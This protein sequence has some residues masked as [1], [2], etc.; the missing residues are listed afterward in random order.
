MSSLIF[1]NWRRWLNEVSMDQ[2]LQVL[3]SKKTRKALEKYSDYSQPAK[4]FSV[5]LRGLLIDN[6]DVS[7]KDKALAIMWLASLAKRDRKVFELVLGPPEKVG[8]DVDA[9]LHYR[10]NNLLNVLERFFHYQRF[11][12]KKD[13]LRISSVDELG[14]IVTDAREEIEA[15]QNRQIYKDAAAGTEVLRDDARWYI[16]AIHNKGAACELGKG[17]KWCTAAPGLDYFHGYYQKDSPLFFFKDKSTGKRY[18]FSYSAEDFGTED[19]NQ[20]SIRLRLKLSD[21]LYA[22]GKA[23][24]YGDFVD[25]Y[26]NDVCMALVD[27]TI[28]NIDDVIRYI[29]Y[30]EADIRKTAVKALHYFIENWEL[31][32]G[33]QKEEYLNHEDSN[34]RKVAKKLNDYWKNRERFM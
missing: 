21:L 9:R 32:S 24:K 14:H 13:L 33:Q 28:S 8:G 20:V 26:V 4:L 34:V 7:E 19:N 16:A 22:T 25:Y 11:M 17:T 2:A 30:R 31:F 12:R 6:L 27:G 1:E 15:Y 3:Q 5:A 29:S 18:Q 23:H 10:Q